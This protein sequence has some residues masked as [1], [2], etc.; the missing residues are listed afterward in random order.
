MSDKT[1][2]AFL[3]SSIVI[4]F[5]GM[6][7]IAQEPIV[8]SKEDVRLM[9]IPISIFTDKEL[10]R[11]ELDEYVEAGRLSV[12]ENKDDQQILSIKSVSNQPLAIAIL[13]QDDLTS[14]VNLQLEGIRNF[15]RGLPED[16]RVMV[17]YLRGGAPQVRQSFT[18]DLDAAA[19]SLRVVTSSSATAPR[20]P[21]GS[22]R[23]I[24]NRFDG[25]PNGRRAVFMVSD[26]L[27]TSSGI[28][29]ASPGQSLELGRAIL[30]A[31]K[32]GI[33]VY[34]IY[35]SASQTRSGNSTLVSFGQGSLNRLGDETG[36][37]SYFQG[38][39]S[40]VSFKPF[41]LKL[42]RSLTRQFALTYLSTHMKSGYYK[43]KVE[44]TNP[45]VRIDHPK[46]Y[47]YKKRKKNR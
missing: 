25:L 34:S 23:K 47:Y 33:A 19:N 43:V 35:S 38:F 31:Q 22:L 11:N 42:G 15:I 30:A 8:N 41:F 9:T 17:A 18:R 27:D 3:C 37:R 32:R 13:L 4:L 36:G 46:R 16:S 28:S 10:K 44:S 6:L 26:G 1:I 5:S 14:E 29:S 24:L 40:P 20:S 45:E 21:F 2:R 12:H 7:V 39:S